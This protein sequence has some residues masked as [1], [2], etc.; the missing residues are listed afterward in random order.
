MNTRL[1]QKSEATFVYHVPFVMVPSLGQCAAQCATH[2]VR[3]PKG[4]GKEQM[5]RGNEG[6]FS[7]FVAAQR[8]TECA[9][10]PGVR[11]ETWPSLWGAVSNANERMALPPSRCVPQNSFRRKVRFHLVLCQR[12][13]A[14]E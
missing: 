12:H 10:L 11:F 3:Q 14:T 9:V 5:P 7:E 2:T 6:D 13:S 1:S 8:L 4:G